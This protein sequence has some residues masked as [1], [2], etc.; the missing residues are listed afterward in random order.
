[1]T[2]QATFEIRLDDQTSGASNAAAKS[3]T[4]L[5][6]RIQGSTGELA[7]MQAAMKRMQAGSSVNVDAFRRLQKAIDNKKSSLAKMEEQYALLGGTFGKLP[8]KMKASGDK[9]AQL[10]S[11]L[12][13]ANPQ[14]SGAI[15]GA[16][17]LGKALSSVGLAGA[18]LAAA[19]A[20]LA[21]GTGLAA[22]GLKIADTVRQQRVQMM[23]IA[24]LAKAYRS[25]TPEM[26]AM[27]GGMYALIA[28]KAGAAS[29]EAG[30]ALT[31]MVNRVTDSFAVGRE[32]VM[33]YMQSLIRA[34]VSGKNLEAALEGA[35]TMSSVFG[36]EAAGQFITMSTQAQFFG[37][38]VKRIANNVQAKFGEAARSLKL[39]LGAQ[40]TQLRTNLG[41]LFTGLKIEGFLK[42]MN[43]VLS[44]F[45]QST[46]SGRALKALVETMLQPLYDKTSGLAPILKNLWRGMVIGALMVTVVVL[47]I[48]NAFRDAFGKDTFANIDWVNL[49]LYAGATAG[50]AL[51]AAIGIIAASIAFTVARI[52]MIVHGIAWFIDQFVWAYDFLKSWSGSWSELGSLFV[53]G[54]VL[55]IMKSWS[56]SW[57]ELGSLFVEGL[58]LGIMKSW[59]GSWSEL[60][61]LFVEGLVLGIKTAAGKALDAV[62]NLGMGIKN[63]FKSVMQI[64]SPS[65]VFFG[66]GANIGQGA[67]LGMRAMQPQVDE[68]AASMAPEPQM[69]LPSAQSF[70]STTN[71]AQRGPTTINISIDGAG[72]DAK[73]IAKQ[74]WEIVQD[75]LEGE[76]VTIGGEL[77]ST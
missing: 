68:A 74:V 72:G 36:E 27:G 9:M 17:G 31:G 16:T 60:G 15:G 24:S 76:V 48:R 5:R 37:G 71:N 62:K 35:A 33:G 41:R 57:S 66:F 43:E 14:L 12:A 50:V 8:G 54:L 53:E 70:V 69:P 59:S 22:L 3:L 49:A 39:G 23:G 29:M 51:A 20:V 7:R 47:K 55:G 61:S 21:L 45:S 73:S 44:L 4:R 52:K 40:L 19:A 42:G 6:E 26:A 64:Q 63:A 75:H 30:D 56:G 34:R 11:L 25:L 65:K 28:G 32:Q 46:A 13:Q 10:S 58:V 18:A 67:V 77:L 2:E 1:M 38:S